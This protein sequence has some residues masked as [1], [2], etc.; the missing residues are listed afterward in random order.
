MLTWTTG[1]RCRMRIQKPLRQLQKTAANMAGKRIQRVSCDESPRFAAHFLNLACV[2]CSSGPT[3]ARRINCCSAFLTRGGAEALRAPLFAPQVKAVLLQPQRL[4]VVVV[5]PQIVTVTSSFLVT[6]H[7][8]C[9]LAGT[10]R[11]YRP[12][13]RVF[14]QSFV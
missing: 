9:V 2:V 13:A 5:Q 10:P 11:Y 1:I 7:S 12:R 3:E 8:L 6:C 4:A 14:R